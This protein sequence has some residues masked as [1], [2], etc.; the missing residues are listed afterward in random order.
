[1]RDRLSV[2]ADGRSMQSERYCNGEYATKGPKHWR[3]G[4]LADKSIQD[5]SGESEWV[6][7]GPDGIPDFDFVKGVDGFQNSVLF[8]ACEC[9][10]VFGERI[11]RI[12]MKSFPNTRLAVIDDAG[13]D[14][15]AG[16]PEEVTKVIREYLKK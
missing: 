1:M 13:H 9:N 14:L 10:T 4:S 3:G 16:K 2:G 8:I 15:F 7:I 6:S 12:H 5:L 11:Q